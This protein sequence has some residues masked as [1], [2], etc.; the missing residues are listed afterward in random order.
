[1]CPY[2]I[3]PFRCSVM[4]SGAQQWL[5]NVCAV[6]L[7]TM[8]TAYPVFKKIQKHTKKSQKHTQKKRLFLEEM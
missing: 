2:L 8:C 7:Q 5:T 4:C 1:M 6:M 3:V